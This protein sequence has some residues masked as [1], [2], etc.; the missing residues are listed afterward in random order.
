MKDIIS[1]SAIIDNDNNANDEDEQEYIDGINE[2]DRFQ[3]QQFKQKWRFNKSHPGFHFSQLCELK[4]MVIPKVYLQK[5]KLCNI[6]DVK[7]QQCQSDVDEDVKNLRE[8]YTKMALMMFY[9]YRTHCDLLKNGSHWE[10]FNDERTR[11]FENKRQTNKI[12]HQNGDDSCHQ[13]ELPQSKFWE[14]GFDI[15]QNMQNRNTMEN[16]LSKRARDKVTVDTVCQAPDPIPGSSNSEHPEN[17]ID[18]VVDILKYC[19]EHRRYVH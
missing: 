17:D 2:H 6:E 16:K 19:N 7:L 11:Y 5:G 18:N 8:N 14:K 9:P 10:L 1:P 3:G 12:Q 13:P 4:K 15:L